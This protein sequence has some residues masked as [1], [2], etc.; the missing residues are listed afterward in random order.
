MLRVL[1]GITL[2]VLFSSCN[3]R[4]KSVAEYNKWLNDADNG[5]ISN[6]CIAGASYT[7]KYL[8]PEYSVLKDNE[9]HHLSGEQRDSAIASYDRSLCFLLTLGPD[10]NQKE[11]NRQTSVMYAGINDV[12]DYNNRVFETNFSMDKNIK[13]YADG[14]EYVPV[15]SIV[16]NLYELTDTRNFLVVFASKD[17]KLY[18][19]KEYTLVYD[20]P[21]YNM[22]QIQSRFSGFNLRASR[23]AQL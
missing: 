16:E 18:N 21:Y 12:A 13:L 19:A 15:Y 4:V 17:G 8:P 2:L 5:C 6:R 23:N 14:N 22:G 10:R 1:K 3:S 20:D 11:E 9:R 7:V